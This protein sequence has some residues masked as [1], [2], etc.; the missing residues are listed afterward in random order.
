[1]KSESNF[2]A[3]ASDLMASCCFLFLILLSSLFMHLQEESKG[4]QDFREYVNEPK[5]AQTAL[6]G[7][8]AAMLKNQGLKVEVIPEQGILR[9]Q[10]PSWGF[11]P[12]KSHPPES[13]K[14]HLAKLAQSLSTVMGCAVPNEHGYTRQSICEK[15]PQH[16]YV[17]RQFK[18]VSLEGITI[19]GHTDNRP[20]LPTSGF[21]D[22]L[23]L[24]AARASEVYRLLEDC[25]P[26]MQN[27]HNEEG[28]K[29]MSVAGY[30][31]TRPAYSNPA[32]SG[33]RRIDIRIRLS[34]AS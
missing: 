30:A 6:L 22:N 7:D 12:G 8:L 28:Q 29:I 13:Q 11:L 5:R 18:N 14:E 2:W 25:Q 1:M 4:F 26:D 15:T 17:C 3:S 16:I 10:E 31:D 27:W 33:N 9:L 19:E 32:H 24:S 20:V 21:Q 23:A 34:T